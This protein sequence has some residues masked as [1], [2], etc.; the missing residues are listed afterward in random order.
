[1]KTLIK[2]TTPVD[3]YKI[4]TEFHKE[5]YVSKLDEAMMLFISFCSKHKTFSAKEASEIINELPTEDYIEILTIS[6]YIRHNYLIDDLLQSENKR[7]Y[8]IQIE[9]RKAIEQRYA[10]RLIDDDDLKISLD[11]A[12]REWRNREQNCVN[13]IATIRALKDLINKFKR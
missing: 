12:E 7:L 1:M 10:L 4:F 3:A 2:E 13:R 11:N 8:L 5:N 6:H 9:T